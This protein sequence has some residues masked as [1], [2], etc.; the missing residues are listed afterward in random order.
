MIE[1][2]AIHRINLIMF[3][4]RSAFVVSESL[5][6][7]FSAENVN[8]K[9]NEP[10][11]TACNAIVVF[12]HPGSGAISISQYLYSRLKSPDLGTKSFEETGWYL[13][14]FND[15]SHR[16]EDVLTVSMKKDHLIITILLAPTSLAS[17]ADVLSKL[18]ASGRVDIRLILTIASESVADE[19]SILDWRNTE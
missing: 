11:I 14:D 5:K 4:S 3:R 9:V 18:E 13:L 7:L 2:I 6:T 17:S 10:Q 15:P 8:I 1:K 19:Y 12:G 16:L